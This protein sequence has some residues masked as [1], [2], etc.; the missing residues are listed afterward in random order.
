MSEESVFCSVRTRGTDN[1]GVVCEE[2]P[3][4]L[5]F[6]PGLQD[7]RTQAGEGRSGDM[8]EATGGIREL[9]AATGLGSGSWRIQVWWLMPVI[10]GTWRQ[11]QEDG[12]FEP[13]PVAWRDTVSNKN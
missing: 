6:K 3:E 4:E 5:V 12:R 9:K 10:A 7:G 13:S 1:V 2:F 11:R 8:R